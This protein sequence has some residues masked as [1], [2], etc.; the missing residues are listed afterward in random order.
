MAGARTPEEVRA[1]TYD[2]KIFPIKSV[3][4]SKTAGLSSFLT[5]VEGMGAG[6]RFRSQPD[7]LD[8][9]AKCFVPA[10]DSLK[11][12][13]N[14]LLVTLDGFTFPAG[15]FQNRIAGREFFSLP[16]ELDQEPKSPAQRLARTNGF[17]TI[18][19]LKY[20]SVLRHFSFQIEF[21]NPHEQE[22]L[23]ILIMG[24]SL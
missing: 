8:P 23:A 24:N 1:A 3:P 9:P 5:V 20:L 19:F 15:T 22:A 21:K 12:L 17:Q 11:I 14:V 6:L 16:E 18:T 13:W 4:Q 10:L 2:K 7:A